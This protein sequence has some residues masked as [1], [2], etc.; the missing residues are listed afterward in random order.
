MNGVQRPWSLCENLGSVESIMTC[1]AV[2]THANMLKA[3]RLKVGITDG[4]VRISV[5]LEES[6]D[7]IKALSEALDR[8]P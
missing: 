7:L 3:D 2:M 1:P 4:F 6:D 5:G 8:C